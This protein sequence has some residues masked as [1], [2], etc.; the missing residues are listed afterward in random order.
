MLDLAQA[1]DRMVDAQI[2]G[3]CVRN[4]LLLDAMRRVPREVFIPPD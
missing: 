1:R 3:R 4:L 2:A